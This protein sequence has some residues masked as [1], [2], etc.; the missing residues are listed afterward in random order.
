[1]ITNQKTISSPS[2]E[3]KRNFSR[4][5]SKLKRNQQILTILVLLFVSMTFWIITSLFSSQTSSKI[6]PT[7]NKLAMPLTPTLDTTILDTIDLKRS[8][9]E[10]ELSNFPIYV[11]VR[12]QSTQTERIVPIG[13]A[14]LPDDTTT[15]VS[16][17]ATTSSQLQEEVVTPEP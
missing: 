17:P 8:F 13:T 9:S 15:S 3:A 4:E 7:I 11:V 6:S 5:V 10:E 2:V 16:T 1:M 12:D 14:V